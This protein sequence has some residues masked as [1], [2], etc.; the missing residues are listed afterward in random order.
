MFSRRRP[1][2]VLFITLLFGFAE[3]FGNQVPVSY[4]HLKEMEY[5]K[6]MENNQV[7]KHAI[8]KLAAEYI[9]DGDAIAMNNGTANLEL[10]RCLLDT[11]ERL[12]VVT[13]SPDIAMVL[14]CLLYTSRC[15]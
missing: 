1:V 8:A 3:A 14:I 11:K 12:T 15:V 13:N 9:N 4:T 5:E 7:E 2:L 10:A 6:K